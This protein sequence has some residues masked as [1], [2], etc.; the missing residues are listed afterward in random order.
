MYRALP[1]PPAP[2]NASAEW[3]KQRLVRVYANYNPEKVKD[4]DALLQKYTGREEQVFTKV[5]EKYGVPYKCNHARQQKRRAVV[6]WYKPDENCE[7]IRGL[8]AAV[9]GTY[10][11]SGTHHGGPLFAKDTE[12]GGTPAFLYYWSDAA[13][14]QWQGWWISSSPGKGTHWAQGGGRLARIPS[15]GWMAPFYGPVRTEIE[16]LLVGTAEGANSVSS[17]QGNTR[18]YKPAVEEAT[19]TA[20]KKVQCAQLAETVADGR[21]SIKA[22]CPKPDPPARARRS[23]LPH[24]RADHDKV[25]MACSHEDVDDS[26]NDLSDE[27]NGASAKICTTVGAGL[28]RQLAAVNTIGSRRRPGLSTGAQGKP[29][30]ADDPRQGREPA[31]GQKCQV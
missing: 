12:S 15:L 26:S 9:T 31:Q 20:A 30:L 23:P 5:C 7:D 6:T 11:E 21:C 27:N 19:V 1:E 10:T 2:P 17:E 25:N 29:R 22:N 18:E 3:H 8:P 14:E 24:A 16:V 13:N 28:T 4:V